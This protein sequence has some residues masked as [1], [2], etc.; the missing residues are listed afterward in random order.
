MKAFFFTTALPTTLNPKNKNLYS[1]VMAFMKKGGKFINMER[2]NFLDRFISETRASTPGIGGHC[3]KISGCDPNAVH[4]MQ[5]NLKTRAMVQ[6][7]QE[8]EHNSNAVK[9]MLKRSGA[10]VLDIKY[11][12]L[13]S[14]PS[15]WCA[16]LNFLEISC[17]D[18]ILLHSSLKKVSVLLLSSRHFRATCPFI[19]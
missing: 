6:Y 5:W 16:V 10:P 13:R 18:L 9:D 17:A 12:E 7:L 11:E 1:R 4:T 2:R 19:G 14:Q 8:S 15:A 3:Q